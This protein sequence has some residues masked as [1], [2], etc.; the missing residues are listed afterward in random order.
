MAK[1][2]LER[3]ARK[4]GKATGKVAERAREA[5]LDK[6]ASEIIAKTKERLGDLVHEYEEARFTK[7]K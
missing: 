2:F 7:L 6:K 5:G 4:L 3:L 1:S